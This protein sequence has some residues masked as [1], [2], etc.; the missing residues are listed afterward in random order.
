MRIRT[1][2]A[3]RLALAEIQMLEA[4]LEGE[5]GF[6]RRHELIAATHAFEQRYQHPS[7]RP[8]KPAPFALKEDAVASE[9]AC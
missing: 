7:Y 8:G 6:A 5:D 9:D 1:V 3:Y 2:E 4:A